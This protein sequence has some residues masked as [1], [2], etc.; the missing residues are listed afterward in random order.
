MPSMNGAVSDMYIYPP[1]PDGNGGH[2]DK[3]F[4]GLGCLKAWIQ[5]SEED[6]HI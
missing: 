6:R 2:V 1:I 3:H 5:L 4:C